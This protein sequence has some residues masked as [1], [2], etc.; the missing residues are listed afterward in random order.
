VLGRYGPEGEHEGSSVCRRPQHGPR[1]H[2]EPATEAEP[3]TCGHDDHGDP[4]LGGVDEHV[5]QLAELSPVCGGDRDSQ[6]GTSGEDRWGEDVIV[7]RL[8]LFFASSLPPHLRAT[9]S[10]DPVSNWDG[11]YGT[12]ARCPVRV[13]SR[14]REAMTLAE[15]RRGIPHRTQR[16]PSLQKRTGVPS[17]HLQATLHGHLLGRPCVVA[18][19]YSAPFCGSQRSA[20]IHR[21]SPRESRRRKLTTLK[22]RPR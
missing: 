20:C 22:H 16:E 15:W 1:Q 5:V 2:H 8:A 19:G 10:A 11:L 17:D 14:C 13:R 7:T 21:P 9:L 18:D 12:E 3:P 4:A 6:Q